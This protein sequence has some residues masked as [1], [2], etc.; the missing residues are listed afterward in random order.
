MWLELGEQRESWGNELG[1]ASRGQV[2]QG[3]E[4]PREDCGF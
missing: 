2:T 4:V 1:E 3:L